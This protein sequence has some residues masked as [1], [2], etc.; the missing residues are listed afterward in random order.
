MALEREALDFIEMVKG[1]E[2]PDLVSEPVWCLSD[3]PDP[4]SNFMG[5]SFIEA[6]EAFI[7]HFTFDHGSTMLKMPTE[8]EFFSPITISDHNH[9]GRFIYKIPASKVIEEQFKKVKPDNCA[10]IDPGLDWQG[11]KQIKLTKKEG[12]RSQIAFLNPIN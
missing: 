3:I 5:Q 9:V 1:R 12:E 8:G 2:K 7:A 4:L 6:V 10:I 11:I